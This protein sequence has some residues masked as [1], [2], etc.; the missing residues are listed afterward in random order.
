MPQA[1]LM[2]SKGFLAT[3]LAGAAV[4][5]L[6]VLGTAGPVAA[7]ETATATA[8]AGRIGPGT[9]LVT[10]GRACTANFVF[11]DARGRVFLGY[12][13][14]CATR[15]R[16]AAANACTAR[17]LP[18]G[19]RVRLAVR[20]RTVGYGTLRYS[21]L[22]ALRAAGTT[23]AA[24]CAANDFALVQ[25][26]GAVRRQVS[27]AMPYWGGPTGLAGLPAAGTTVFG[28][29]RLSASARTL[30]RAGQVGAVARSVAHVTTPLPS[31][32]ASRGSGFLDDAGRAVGI[33]TS[34]SSTGDN[35]VVSLADAVS[36][37]RVH[38]VGGLRIVR[39]PGFSGAAVL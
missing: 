32:G 11:R 7:R 37:A 6:T 24:T 33:L 38:G 31:T 8:S 21:S 28:L 27:A 15:S 39:G 4:A 2:H 25:V 3:V 26:R 16:V 13:A 30:P 14:S 34:F 9:Q 5:A 10:G 1:D 35:T 36:F 29:T 12:A 18:M 22:R 19:T 20:G 23:D 17:S